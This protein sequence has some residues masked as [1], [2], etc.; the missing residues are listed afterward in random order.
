MWSNIV[1]LYSFTFIKNPKLSILGKSTRSL[2]VDR[3]V[4]SIF[5][6]LEVGTYHASSE[7]LPMYLMVIT[8]R[9]FINTNEKTNIF[10]SL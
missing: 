8:I 4:V 1:L 9:L 2:G 7:M 6:W 5:S 10:L 3:N